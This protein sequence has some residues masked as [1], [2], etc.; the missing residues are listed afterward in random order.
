MYLDSDDEDSGSF[1]SERR[2]FTRN[3][4]AELLVSAT[5][6]PE[7]SLEDALKV[8]NFMK[9]Q[10]LKVGTVLFK[11]GAKSHNT[12]VLILQ[13]DIVVSQQPPGQAS[14][15]VMTVLGAGHL[16][17]ELGVLDGKPR[18]ATC[19]AA[20]EV[21]VAVLDQVDLEQR[22]FREDPPVGVALLRA[23]LMQ[24][25]ER[26]RATNHRVFM[27]SQI[28]DSMQMEIKD[29]QEQ[30]ESAIRTL[31]PASSPLSSARPRL[32]VG[33]R[34]ANAHRRTR[35]MDDAPNVNADSTRKPELK[36]DIRRRR[37]GKDFRSTY[38]M[39][40]PSQ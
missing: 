18:S 33:P 12:I 17:G 24:V 28:V 15:V 26:L 16:V 5:S 27:L 9:A 37:Q 6:L 22:I 19:T 38:P 30:G 40:G 20:T 2:S 25:A 35:P 21:D 39:S 11:E 36:P 32:P 1:L 3:D 31:P 23:I 14:S 29:Q 10:R 8:V 13:G 4:V 34:P 7:L